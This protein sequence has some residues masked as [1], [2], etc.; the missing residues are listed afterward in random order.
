V[1]GGTNSSLGD[2]E[3]ERLWYFGGKFVF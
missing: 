3:G 1:N 2:S